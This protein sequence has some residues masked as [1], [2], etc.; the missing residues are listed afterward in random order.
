VRRAPQT[1]EEFRLIPQIVAPMLRIDPSY[2]AAATSAHSADDLHELLQNAIRL[3]HATIPPY[4]TA[5]YSLKL[6]INTQIIGIIFS[7]AREEMLHMA[8]VANVLNA[9]GGRPLI[10]HE[11]FVPAYPGPLPMGIAGGLQVG[12]EKFSKYLIHEVFMEI[13]APEHPIHFPGALAT[14]GFATIGQFYRAIRDKIKEL[15]DS[16]VTGDPARQVIR[17]AG[18]PP[19][20]L[21][22][23]MNVDT[24]TRALERVV[25]DGEGTTALPL[26]EDGRL[27][28][29][30][31]FE[32]IVRGRRLIQGPTA[33]NGYS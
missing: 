21:F 10:D 32:Q 6:G 27:A 13:E 30:Y 7:I 12:L 25:K 9:I 4:L 23:I 28:H 24:A 26:D 33:P 19:S 22:A 8:I 29:Y 5:A 15:G 2:V 1:R 20:Q 16:I 3:E 18:F 11:E 17:N 14:A 31:L